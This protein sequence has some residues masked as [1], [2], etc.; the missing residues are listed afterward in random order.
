MRNRSK[1]IEF[2]KI[3]TFF[4]TSER[5]NIHTESLNFWT[6]SAKCRKY[7]IEKRDDQGR[8]FCSSVWEP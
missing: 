6:F 1:V 4:A 2:H 5:L 3:F 8:I 7:I